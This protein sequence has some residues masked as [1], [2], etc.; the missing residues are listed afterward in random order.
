MK[1]ILLF[2]YAIRSNKGKVAMTH[3][4]LSTGEGFFTLLNFVALLRNFLYMGDFFKCSKG[5]QIHKPLEQ[6]NHPTRRTTV[7][8]ELGGGTST[9]SET[10]MHSPKGTNL[11]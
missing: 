4:L 2:K 9:V 8:C 1:E 10:C 3:S 7:G 6:R 11:Y 5:K